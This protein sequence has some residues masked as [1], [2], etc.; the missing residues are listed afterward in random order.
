MKNPMDFCAGIFGIAS[1]Y[2][3]GRSVLII[4]MKLLVLWFAFLYLPVLSKAQI[5]TT[6]AGNGSGTSSGD[7]GAATAA[8]IPNPIG[9]ALDRH[10]NLFIP[11]TLAHRIRKVDI[12]GTITTVA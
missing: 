3:I 1:W 10:G 8:G 12:S 2:K 5:I 6:I 9:L 11:S 4:F 7:W